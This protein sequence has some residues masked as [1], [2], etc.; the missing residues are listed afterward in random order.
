MNDNICVSRNSELG[1]HFQFPKMPNA[2]FIPSR[3]PYLGSHI[4]KYK[5][6]HPLQSTRLW[7]GSP[8]F[9]IPKI[10]LKSIPKIIYQFE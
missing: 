3:W 1:F 4:V 8:L 10:I 2:I 5:E 9:C 7:K 6:M